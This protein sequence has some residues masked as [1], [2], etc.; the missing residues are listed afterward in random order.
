MAEM[1][2]SL[3]TWAYAI[4]GF[5]ALLG[6]LPQ[7][8]VLW[9]NPAAAA[10]TPLFTWVVWSVQTV[11]F[12][13]YAVVVNGDLL[14]MLAT[15]CSMW[16]TLVCLALLLWRRRGVRGLAGRRLTD[17]LPLPFPRKL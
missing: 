4:M 9:R 2:V 1:I 10:H 13:L 11:T 15:G 5:V 17:Q 8:L 7:A 14:F 6:F 3:L 12:H 16:G